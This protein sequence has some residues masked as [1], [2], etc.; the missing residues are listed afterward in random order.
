LENNKSKYV[1]IFKIKIKKIDKYE[2]KKACTLK[3]SSYAA[4]KNIFVD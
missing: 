3:K 2:R 1:Q 4:Y